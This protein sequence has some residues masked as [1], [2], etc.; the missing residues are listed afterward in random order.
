MEKP[1]TPKKDNTSLVTLIVTSMVALIGGVITNF[2]KL[3]HS[4]KAPA[5]EIATNK[6]TAETFDTKLN[7]IIAESATNFSGILGNLREE[8]EIGKSYYSKLNLFDGLTTIYFP[9][10][11]TEKSHFQVDILTTKDLAAATQKYTETFKLVSETLQSKSE[12]AESVEE[13]VTTQ[14]YTFEKG[15]SSVTV[16]MT[17]TTISETEITYEVAL[18]VESK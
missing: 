17:A 16:Y 8:D 10:D 4:S 3:F 13:N 2:D 18:T 12:P 1:V 11:Q 9:I 7:K 5:T 15:N 6:E 14:T